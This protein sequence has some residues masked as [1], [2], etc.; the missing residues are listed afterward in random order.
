MM[1]SLLMSR[2]SDYLATSAHFY[3]RSDLVVRPA[4][5]EHQPHILSSITRSKKI[6][7][8]GPE[9]DH[10]NRK[11]RLPHSPMLRSPH[12][13]V[14]GQWYSLRLPERT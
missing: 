14:E 4:S 6:Y 11:V 10:I 12:L 1:L 9:A 7:S 5:V 8:P 13:T 2:P 3:G